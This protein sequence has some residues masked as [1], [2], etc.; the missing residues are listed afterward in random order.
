MQMFNWKTSEEF[1]EGIV[2]DGKFELKE[3]VLAAMLSAKAVWTFR[4]S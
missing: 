1:F 2:N 3:N 4:E